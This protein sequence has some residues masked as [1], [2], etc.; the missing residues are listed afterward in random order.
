VPPALLAELSSAKSIVISLD[1]VLFSDGTLAGP[2]TRNNFVQYSERL[3]ADREFAAA[4]LSYQS[5]SVS[6]LQSYLDSE[7]ILDRA[8]GLGSQR[9]Y[10]HTLAADARR[11]QMI[12]AKPAPKGG[13]AQVFASATTLA[14]DAAGFTLH[15]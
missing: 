8:G 9:N 5:G 11:F 10:I 13:A 6:G 12:M 4:V 7:A 2:D 3:A 15:K 1:S 14:N